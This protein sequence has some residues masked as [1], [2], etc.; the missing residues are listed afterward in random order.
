MPMESGG[1]ARLS[2][3]MIEIYDL[4][5]ERIECSTHAPECRNTMKPPITVA[6]SI[7]LRTTKLSYIISIGLSFRVCTEQDNDT[8]ICSVQSMMYL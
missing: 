3:G 5:R 6:D 2:R 4:E 8:K 7:P 1:E